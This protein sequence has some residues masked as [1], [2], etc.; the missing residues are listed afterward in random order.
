MKNE[1]SEAGEI[2]ATIEAS[3]KDMR[4]YIADIGKDLKSNGDHSALLKEEL[5]DMKQ[6]LEE[7]KREQNELLNGIIEKQLTG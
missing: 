7:T 1:L 3:S 4:E 5:A 6:T 2:K